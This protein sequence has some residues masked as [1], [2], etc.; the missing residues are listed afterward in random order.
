VSNPPPPPAPTPPPPPP[1]QPGAEVNAEPRPRV[2][3][4][5]NPIAIAAIIV[6]VLA[7]ILAV[8][9]VGFFVASV[10]GVRGIVAL[11]RAR[12]GRRG[13]GIAITSIVLSLLAMA[14]S[15]VGLLFI[16]SIVRSGETTV[17]DG[18]ATNSDNVE[19]PPQDDIDDVE[20]SAS[21]SGRLAQARVTITN[22]SEGRSV[23]RLT[24]EWD[25]PSG[26]PIE[27]VITTG[28]VDAGESATLEA[29][30]LSGTAVQ[31]S[32]RITRIDR[33]FLPFF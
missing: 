8:I 30:D 15:V 33:S 28:F 12:R 3:D 18:I 26:D 23:Y 20:C 24:L 10:S 6:S 13:R 21:N 9:V 1:R 25:T 29:V 7:L 5:D 11:R 19:Y 17:R 16:V 22:R 4:H 2:A 27:E 14:F 31:D 32:C